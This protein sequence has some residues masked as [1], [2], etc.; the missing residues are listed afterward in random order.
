M[1]KYSRDKINRAKNSEMINIKEVKLIPCEYD[2][3]VCY[4]EIFQ[5]F[6]QIQCAYL[7]LDDGNVKAVTK[8]MKGMTKE[9]ILGLAFLY[10]HFADFASAI[11]SLRVLE[12]DGIQ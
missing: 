2:K 12:K 6:N 4:H 8:K 5:I 11:G 10:N 1:T 7:N 3:D 9:M